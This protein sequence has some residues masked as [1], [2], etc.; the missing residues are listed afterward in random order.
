M[1]LSIKEAFPMGTQGARFGWLSSARGILTLGVIAGISVLA[2]AILHLW[3]QYNAAEQRETSRVELFARILE[4]QTT[5]TFN[6]VELTLGTIADFVQ[7]SGDAHLEESAWHNEWL[8]ESMRRSPFI[9]SLSLIDGD[10]LVLASSNVVNTGRRIGMLAAF[11]AATGNEDA[12]RLGRP[13]IGRDIGDGQFSDAPRPSAAYVIPVMLPFSTAGGRRMGVL[14]AVNPDFFAN[15]FERSIDEPKDTAM[16]ADYEG[17]FF[18]GTSN[19]RLSPGADVSGIPVFARHLLVREHGSFKYEAHG[20][21]EWITGFRTSRTMPLVLVVEAGHAR[22]VSEW[23]AGNRS[24]ALLGLALELLVFAVTWFA[25]GAARAREKTQAALEHQLRYTNELFE[26]SPFPVFVK[27]AEGV[28]VSV[29]KAWEAFRGIRRE[30]LSGHRFTPEIDPEIEARHHLADLHAVRTGQPVRYE[31]TI[32]G[33]DGTQRHVVV[34]KAAIRRAD[35]GPNGIVGTLIDLTEIKNAEREAGAARDAA[36]EAARVKGQFLANMSHEIRT[37]MNGI[38][39]MTRLALETPLNAEQRGYLETVQSSGKALL[40]II[41]DVLDFSKIE[42]GKLVLEST[43]FVLTDEVEAAVRLLAPQA[44]D[45][46]L[47]LV[48]SIDHRLP[49]TVQG[50]PLR[51][52][53]VLINLLGNAVKFTSHGEVELRVSAH[54]SRAGE[55]A[56]DFSVRDTGPGIPRAKQAMV[57]EGFSQADASTTR[58]FGGTGL[59][60]AISARLVALMGGKIALES[61]HGNGSRFHFCLPMSAPGPAAGPAATAG[62]VSGRSVLLAVGHPGARKAA[63]EQLLAAGAK[64]HAVEDLAGVDPGRWDIAIIDATLRGNAVYEAAEKVASS[65]AAT[66]VFVLVPTSG[67]VAAAA[68]IRARGVSGQLRKPFLLRE[69]ATLLEPPKAHAPTLQR[70]ARSANILLAEDHP[71][72]Q[73]LMRS[74]LTRM[75]HTVTIAG[76]GQEAL[77]ALGHGSFDAVLM[78]VQMPVMGGMDATRALRASEAGSGRRIPVIALTAHA[79]E[80]DRAACLD[81][82]MDD[83]LT[84]PVDPE[85]LRAALDRWVAEPEAAPA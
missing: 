21:G 38:L 44:A 78:D 23:V 15:Y 63:E 52:R 85:G 75:G 41:N 64:V 65:G 83:Y 40:H 73:A 8:A 80:G 81:A 56:V 26:G 60:L 34:H 76:T 53:Q 50:D 4:D 71:V 33:V 59:G 6:S 77:D 27:N 24:F 58:K 67:P 61:E 57:F 47:E 62:R 28:L 31:I 36:E 2:I 72:N 39:G 9:R 43:D 19:L 66:R 49:H 46:S 42:A 54:A 20:R 32:P 55:V 17:R 82:G 11:G 30:E 18:T 35:G 84:K 12:L 45:K 51:L 10:G 13:A 5:R 79:M 70:A 48:A 37:P 7:T 25:V 74:L 14:A 69:L 1:P 3:L 22:I 68:R 16:L 29:N